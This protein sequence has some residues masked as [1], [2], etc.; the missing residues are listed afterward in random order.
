M[1]K[2][3]NVTENYYS[4]KLYKTIKH[5]VLHLASRFLCSGGSLHFFVILKGNNPKY[6]L[7]NFHIKA[8]PLIFDKC[9]R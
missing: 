2:E 5:K 1:L 4:Y 6:F 8:M 3:R 7:P 9:S